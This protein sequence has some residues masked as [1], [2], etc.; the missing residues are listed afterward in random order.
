MAA[1]IEYFN[2]R[3]ENEHKLTSECTDLQ[4]QNIS[5]LENNSDSEDD[6][7]TDSEPR[8][9]KYQNVDNLVVK[10]RNILK[11]KKKANTLTETAS[12]L[13]FSH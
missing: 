5:I 9:M 10:V 13:S 11:K 6:S 7:D 1:A 12:I 3:S 8:F 4:F 2:K